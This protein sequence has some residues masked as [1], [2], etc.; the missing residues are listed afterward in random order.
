MR[1]KYW[2]KALIWWTTT[3]C[4]PASTI[5]WHLTRTAMCCSH[6]LPISALKPFCSHLI[7]C[8]LQCR[9]CQPLACQVCILSRMPYWS[10]G[11]S[12]D[13][14]IPI[15]CQY[16]L[17]QS[18]C[19]PWWQV[20][21]SPPLLNSAQL[22]CQMVAPSQTW[23]PFKALLLDWTID[24]KSSQ[25]CTP[26]HSN[27]FRSWPAAVHH[28]KCIMTCY[29]IIIIIHKLQ[30]LS[31]CRLQGKRFQAA[32]KHNQP[33]RHQLFPRPQLEASKGGH[34]RDNQSLQS[35]SCGQEHDSSVRPCSRSASHVCQLQG[36]TLAC[37]LICCKICS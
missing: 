13:Q 21:L 16:R 36:L 17:S 19:P 34:C 9:S 29:W 28:V 20:R 30:A 37:E 35:P 3:S 14:S 10:H 12:E 6:D 4:I 7:S 32:I 26:F 5:K 1:L 24:S 15:L 27:K 18:L 2:L 23:L 11:L 8:V 22:S 25:A 31:L 33:C